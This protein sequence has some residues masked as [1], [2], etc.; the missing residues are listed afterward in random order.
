MTGQ[1]GRD[2]VEISLKTAR[3]LAVFKQHLAGKLPEE[4]TS[5][6]ILSIV[7]DLAFVQW[8]PISIVAPSHILAI[9]ARLGA[10][11]VSD[12]DR[13]LWDEKKAFLF[14]A[15]MASIVL[16]ED[17]P[18]YRSLMTRYPDSM[19]NSW[20]SQREG[21]RKFLREHAELREKML[22]ELR[23]GP[24]QPTQFEDYQ[25]TKRRA[26]DW[27][28]GSDIS[29]MLSHMHMSGEVMVVGH[30]RNQNLWG[31]SEDYLPMSVRRE[32]MAEEEF[33]QKAA[34]RAIQALGTASPKE[35]HHYFVRGRYQ[36][37]RGALASLQKECLIQRVSVDGLTKKD[38]RF[39]HSDD[40]PLLESL[41]SDS[42]EPR[43]SLLPPF[44]NM[45]GSTDR[46]KRLFGFN[47]VREQF[48]P[49]EKRR[50]GT[51]VLPILSGEKFIGR[52]D[53]RVDHDSDTL[54][55]NSIHVEPDVNLDEDIR[56]QIRD[57]IE[58]LA[59]FLG[60]RHTAYPDNFLHE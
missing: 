29:A 58:Q 4:P 20:G 25:R 50:Y 57:K 24:L 41:G 37:L 33:E 7:R 10:F 34:H 60:A 13:L 6:R 18:L 9:W 30:Q 28:P 55:I 22:K 35:I 3:R 45:L 15:P 31:L 46:T 27:T 52:I 47:Y 26:L 16:T 56:S 40:I 38:E 49:K 42:W 48:L 17:Y 51:Y 53:P 8:D 36:N 43:I 5:D 23:K 44:D 11:R 59:E 39:I 21:A 19:S 54:V 1:Q 12:L 32:E 14:W 2:T